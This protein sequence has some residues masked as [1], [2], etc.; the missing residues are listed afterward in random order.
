[1]PPCFKSL[2]DGQ[3]LTIVS[4]ILSFGRNYFAREV[5]HKM[6]L[7]WVI[8]QLTQHSTNSMPTRVNFNP[9]VSFQIEVL[10][11]RRFNKSL[12]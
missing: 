12:T 3:K 10:K 9:D 5:G 6:P 11:D 1:M 7:A 4:F 8:S 2:N